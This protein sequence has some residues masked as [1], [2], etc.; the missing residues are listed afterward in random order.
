VLEAAHQ[1]NEQE[2]DPVA[3]TGMMPTKPTIT[4]CRLVSVKAKAE[5]EGLHEY[6]CV[7]LH[8]GRESLFSGKS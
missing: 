2:V 3:H 4:A 1:S 8:F 6:G 5:Q 7:C